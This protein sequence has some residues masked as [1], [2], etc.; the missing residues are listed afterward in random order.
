VG[1]DEHVEAE[2]A[3]RDHELR[4]RQVVQV[5]EQEERR[6]GACLPGVGKVLGR[7]EK[8]FGEQRERGSGARGS[9]V[10]P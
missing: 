1:F 9:E 6:V 5:A 3:G 10:V 7:G 2:L 8:P 4:G